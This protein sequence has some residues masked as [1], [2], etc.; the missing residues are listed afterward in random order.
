MWKL[1]KDI[2]SVGFQ[3]RHLAGSV[4]RLLT[5]AKAQPLSAEQLVALRSEPEPGAEAA[6][7]LESVETAYNQA[8]EFAR[9]TLAAQMEEPRYIG[10]QRLATTLGLL[11]GH[12]A[13]HTQR[14]TGQAIVV[15]KL[16][17]RNSLQETRPE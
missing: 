2:G 10:R 4:D 17:A 13:E 9:I 14:H 3:L 7:L 11:L 6:E 8:K 12:I 16:A 15:S 5:Y 1:Y